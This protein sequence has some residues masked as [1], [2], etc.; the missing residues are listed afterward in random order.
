MNEMRQLIDLIET[1]EA[2]ALEEGILTS[3]AILGSLMALLSSGG[4]KLPDNPEQALKSE[5]NKIMQDNIYD[6]NTVDV[7]KHS[8]QKISQMFGVSIDRIIDTDFS[9]KMGSP[10]AGLA[11]DDLAKVTGTDRFNIASTSVNAINPQ[12]EGK[13]HTKMGKSQV[14]NVG[15]YYIQVIRGTQFVGTSDGTG[16]VPKGS[17]VYITGCDVI[18]SVTLKAGTVFAGHR[19]TIEFYHT[20]DENLETLDKCNPQ[21]LLKALESEFRS[22]PVYYVPDK[23]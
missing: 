23:A 21:A 9:R 17:T 7:Y 5:V 16:S 19:Q 4:E 18:G 2:E 22:N 15:E 8:P 11:F 6:K 20:Y 12:V 13:K 10:Q 14:Y 1:A 3:A